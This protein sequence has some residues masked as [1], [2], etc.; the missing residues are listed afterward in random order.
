MIVP[1]LPRFSLTAEACPANAVITSNRAVIY[2]IS[3]L[4]RR[5]PWLLQTRDVV[6]LSAYI[7]LPPIT[8]LYDTRD[9]SCPSHITR[10]CLFSLKTCADY[11][12]PYSYL[13]IVSGR[14]VRDSKL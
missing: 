2:L 7:H 14:L 13:V 8:M 9:M 6:D 10:S 5:Q 1:R 4:C 12:Q 11:A 3:T